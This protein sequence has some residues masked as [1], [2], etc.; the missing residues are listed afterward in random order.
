MAARVSTLSQRASW[1]ADFLSK[2]LHKVLPSGRLSGLRHTQAR[3]PAV[4]LRLGR[5][6]LLEASG[7]VGGSAQDVLDVEEELLRSITAGERQAES[8]RSDLRASTYVQE[9]LVLHGR[10]HGVGGVVQRVFPGMHQ[11]GEAELSGWGEEQPA[12]SD[13]RLLVGTRRSPARRGLTCVLGQS[14]LDGD[15]VLQRLG[16]F[17]AGDGQVTRVQEVPDPVVVVEEG[18]RGSEPEPALLRRL[19]VAAVGRYLRLGQLVVVVGEPQVKAPAVDVHGLS[20]DGAGHGGTFD[21][22]ARPPLKQR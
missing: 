19:S 11:E 8:I 20:Q 14:L 13:T 1:T 10:L 21:V 18:L 5:L 15:E 7:D 2:K 9:P 6:P 22:P 3:L 12:G 17:A 4:E 16:H